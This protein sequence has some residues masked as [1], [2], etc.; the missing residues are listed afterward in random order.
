VANPPLRLISADQ[1]KDLPPTDILSGTRFVARGLNVV[2]GASGAFKSFY[3]LSAALTVAQSLP[4]VYIAAEGAGGLSARVGAWCNYHNSPPGSLHFICEEINLRNT[5]D[6]SRL[7]RA[8]NPVKPQLIVIDTLARCMIGGDENSAKDVGLAIHGCSSL[9]R[10]F[11]AAICLI[12]HTNKADRGERG[13]GALRGAADTMIEVVSTGDGIIRASCS[14]SKDY[15]PWEPEDLAFKQVDTSGVLI[16]ASEKDTV[17]ISL[18]MSEKTILQFLAL[19]V[20]ETVG[21][22]VQQI[23]NALNISER[24]V[25]RLLSGL[26]NKGLIHHV[27]KLLPMVLTDVGRE[28]LLTFTDKTIPISQT[29]GKIEVE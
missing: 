5:D 13:S 28:M 26:K 12:H 8:L 6:I 7:A 2:F 27:S 21:A 11:S 15:E 3:V 25:Y 17:S 20:F 10:T 1:L 16:S 22:Q 14:K 9:Q 18:T 19:S 24:H 29:L 4:V 23:V